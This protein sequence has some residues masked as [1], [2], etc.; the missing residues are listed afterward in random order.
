MSKRKIFAIVGIIGIVI[1]CLLPLMKCEQTKNVE[2]KPNGVQELIDKKQLNTDSLINES[3]KE[4][5][6]LNQAR[7]SIKLLDKRLRKKATVIIQQAP[8]QCDSFLND[9]IVLWN[10]SDSA[11]QA[12]TE[13][14][15]K[16]DSNKDK[17]IEGLTDINVLTKYQLKQSRDSTKAA[18]EE[19]K[20]LTKQVKK[21]KVKGNFKTIGASIL[22]LFAGFGL[23]KATP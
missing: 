6:L 13:I 16:V 3:L 11:K 9:I 17:I 14:R 10:Q 20:Y 23:S 5:R 8:L 7:D 21:E 1:L 12:E 19:N 22:S 18:K 4:K 15:D 2:V